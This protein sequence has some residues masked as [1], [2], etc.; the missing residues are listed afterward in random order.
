M[1]NGFTFESLYIYISSWNKFWRLQ[2]DDLEFVGNRERCKESIT[3]HLNL[4][5]AHKHSVHKIIHSAEDVSGLP[6]PHD[7]AQYVTIFCSPSV[8]GEMIFIRLEL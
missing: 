4:I 6:V 7:Y 3:K 1:S 8:L 2:C 5:T